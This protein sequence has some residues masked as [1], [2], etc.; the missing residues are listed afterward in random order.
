MS[1]SASS[2]FAI[3]VVGLVFVFCLSGVAGAQTAISTGRE[4][5]SYHAI[6]ERLQASLAADQGYEISVSPSSGSTQNL[7]RLADPSSP[8]GLV[9]TQ[10]DAL[11]RFVKMNPEFASEYIV[12]GDA[13]KECVLAIGSS[14]GSLWSFANLA[15]AEGTEVSVDGPGTGAAVTFGYLL[16]KDPDLSGLKIVYTDVMEA[17]L[18]LQVG[19]ANSALGVVM[20]VQ[21]PSVRSEVVEVLLARSGDY[22]LL[23]IY[24]SD[25]QGGR[26]PDESSVY[27]FERVRVGGKSSAEGIEVDTLCM[28]SLLLASK[29]KLD[30]DTR[31]NLSRFMLMAGPRVFA[32]PE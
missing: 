22:R 10:S 14:K 30:R 26:L 4:G 8:V 5:G 17:M 11:A 13:G 28:R 32:D 9:L 27:T 19:A 31:S 7:A 15:A 21:R 23:P 18:Q 25:V 12:L 20:I 1:S 6:G 2:L 29:S 3:P 24:A 16:E